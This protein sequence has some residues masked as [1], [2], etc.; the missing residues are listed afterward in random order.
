MGLSLNDLREVRMNCSSIYVRRMHE[1]KRLASKKKNKQGL[2]QNSSECRKVNNNFVGAA[3]MP[4]ADAIN[5]NA[6]VSRARDG[7]P[8]RRSCTFS[9]S[10]IV[11]RQP[12]GRYSF[13][14]PD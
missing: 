14:P 7:V 4:P 12:H 9:V 10:L 3:F 2:S 5:G 13:D 1:A 6:R 11:L 8:T